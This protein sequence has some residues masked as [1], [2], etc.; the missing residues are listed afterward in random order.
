MHKHRAKETGT[1]GCW[2]YCITPDECAAKPSRQAAHGGI[3][4]RET[5]SCGATR[6]VES[7]AGRRNASEWTKE[8]E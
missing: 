3:V 5:C 4:Y 1:V 6:S 2:T 7:S 8:G